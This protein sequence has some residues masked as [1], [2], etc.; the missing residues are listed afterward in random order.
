MLQQGAVDMDERIFHQ[1]DRL[2]RG[3]HS[4]TRPPRHVYNDSSTEFSAYEGPDNGYGEPLPYTEGSAYGVD[5][6]QDEPM[7]LDSF[8]KSF[9]QISGY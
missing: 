7:T 3:A 1:L 6:L 4:G 9:D 5:D 8:G 2:Q